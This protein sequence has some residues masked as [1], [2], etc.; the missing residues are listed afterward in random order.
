MRAS[1]YLKRILKEIHQLK[2][3]VELLRR[4]LNI[5]DTKIVRTETRESSQKL[6]T[7]CQKKEIPEG[8]NPRVRY[9]KDNSSVMD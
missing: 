6:G 7:M 4:D 2:F 9:L 8:W 5:I 3:E 1:E